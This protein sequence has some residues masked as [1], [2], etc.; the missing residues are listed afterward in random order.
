MPV[1]DVPANYAFDTYDELVAAIN[2]WL[3]RSDLTGTAQ[4]MI[5]LCE[6]RLRR[7]LVPYFSQASASVVTDIL[8]YGALPADY[9]TANRVIYGTATLPNIS[10]AGGLT[11][12]TSYTQPY[13]YS[14]EA[15]SLKVWPGVAATVT[16]LYQPLLPQL[17][18]GTPSNSLLSAHPDLYFFGALMF[19]NGYVANDVRAGLFKQLWDEAISEAKV[20]LTRQQ[21]S[22][23]M[24]PRV[25]N[26]P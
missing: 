17:S 4:Q 5:A 24:T 25:A 13:A 11:V 14:I 16:L 7:E 1:F 2:D 23:E 22:G 10:G 6:A 19:A 18:V 9:G 15:G 21:F 3:D 20:Y 12:S 8:G 26:I